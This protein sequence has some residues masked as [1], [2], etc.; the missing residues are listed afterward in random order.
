MEIL[1]MMGFIPSYIV[2]VGSHRLAGRKSA[3]ILLN[4]RSE[5]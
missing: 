4:R 2:E 3:E 1:E 5:K